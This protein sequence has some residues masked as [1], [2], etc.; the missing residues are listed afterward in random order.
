M[1]KDANKTPAFCEKIVDLEKRTV[2]FKYANGLLV[3]AELDRLNE[4]MK[5]RCALHGLSQ[6]GGDAYSGISKSGDYKAGFSATQGV[7]DSLYNGVW[8]V[9]GSPNSDLAE[10]FVRLSQAPDIE[11]AQAMIAKLDAE[12]LKDAMS[13]LQVKAVIKAIQLE[14]ANEAAKAA[15]GKGLSLAEILKKAMEPKEEAPAE[16]KGKKK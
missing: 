11:T 9:K 12:S 10:A 6:K 14:R 8:S 13:D 15:A 16:G 2:T 7:I 3:V 4:E 1:A 5:L